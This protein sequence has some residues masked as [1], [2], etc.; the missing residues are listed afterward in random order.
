MT[1]RRRRRRAAAAALVAAAA[2]GRNQGQRARRLRGAPNRNAFPHSSSSVARIRVRVRVAK[3]P[4]E[5]R[6]T[7]SSGGSIET[8]RWRFQLRKAR[9]L[10]SRYVLNASRSGGTGR[11]AGLKIRWRVRPVWVRFPPSAPR[12]MLRRE[13]RNPHRRRRLPRAERGHPGR[14][15]A[16]VRRAGTRSS[17]CARAGAGSSTGSF[18]PLG[19]ARDLRAPAARRH[20]PRHLAHEPVQGRTAASSA[21]SRTSREAASTRSSRSAART[22]SASRRG[23]TPSTSFPVVGVPK[24]IDNDLSA[25]DYT[26]G[27][28]TAVSICDRGDRPAAHDRRVAQ[29]RDGASR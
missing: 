4:G 22:R 25:T 13:G 5:C 8:N 2:A 17:A 28:D 14:R 29:P 24:T 1:F 7:A 3:C 20:D 9:S 15:A 26:F 19:A 12:R 16:V 23:S 6:R 18:E 27:F 10:R 11:R 21:C